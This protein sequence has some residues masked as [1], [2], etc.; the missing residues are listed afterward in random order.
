[1][2]K[3]EFCKARRWLVMVVMVPIDYPLHPFFIST[4][5][6]AK[7]RITT[8]MR[9]FSEWKI[10][11]SCSFL[12]K[13]KH[14]LFSDHHRFHTGFPIMWQSLAVNSC[15]FSNMVLSTV[16]SLPCIY[17]ILYKSL[18]V[19]IK[20]K[21]RQMVLDKWHFRVISNDIAYKLVFDLNDI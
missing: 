7:R 12:P 6:M 20:K 9:E 10:P 3:E 17:I 1:M 11:S 4:S 5:N 15:T 8:R 19:H 2:M 14:Q 16:F 18:W 21:T 13:D